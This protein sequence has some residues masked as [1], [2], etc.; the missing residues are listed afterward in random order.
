MK[1]DIVLIGGGG[2]CKSCIDVIEQ[3]GGYRI[4]G[5]VDMPARIGEQIMG[6]DIIGSDAQLP[7][8]IARYRH[9][10]VSLG[11][12]KSAEARQ[13]IF[14]TV[15]QSGG[16]LPSIV[17]PLAYVS[18]HAQIGQGSIIMHRALV[19]AQARIGENC[20]INTGAVIEHDAQIGDHCHVSTGAIV[21]GGACIEAMSFLGSHATVFQGRTVAQAS[22]IGA[23]VVVKESVSGVLRQRPGLLKDGVDE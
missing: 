4:V 19:N 1:R 17:S 14:Q 3:H 7:D 13:R 5:I 18:G 11:Q 12:I 9:C 20:I 15:Q 2:H 22:V 16:V 8:L 23:G 10:L 6:Y 21:N